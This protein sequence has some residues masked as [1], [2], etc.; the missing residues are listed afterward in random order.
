MSDLLSSFRIKNIEFKNRIGVSPMCQYSSK[1]GF[2]DDWHLVHLGSRAVGGAGLVLTEAAAVSPEG[3]IS[4]GDLGIWKEEHIEKLKQI[5][6]FI[7]AQGAVPGIQLAH[8]GRKASHEAP[9]LGGK[10]ITLSLGG[11]KT[12]AP[13]ALAFKEGESVPEAL[14]KE[15]ICEVIENFGSAA[16]RAWKAGFKVLE[17]HA[18]HGYLIHEFL[19]PLS[20]KRNDEYGGSFENRIRFLLE[21]IRKVRTVWPDESLLFVRISATDW[22]EGGWTIQDSVTLARILK[23][24]GVDLIDCSTGGNS[25]GVKI[26]LVPLY[27]VPFSESIRKE[28]GILTAAVGL[29]TTAAEAE[30]IISEGRADMVFLARELLR[31][32]YF[33]LRAAAELDIQIVWPV[34]YERA[35]KTRQ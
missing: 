5:T 34:Q 19:S 6:S 3:R 27:Q 20:N 1:D 11:W 33:P 18:A 21:L 8:A 23:E 31:D 12:N 17:L 22:V 15:Q 28:T 25:T 10:E 30:S 29:I 32:P 35:K 16:L 2:A 4:P 9:W 26:P 13:S 14:S 7:E 24:A